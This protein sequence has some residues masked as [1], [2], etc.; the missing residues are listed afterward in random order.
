[1]KSTFNKS[2]NNLVTE[3]PSQLILGI[4]L[5]IYI[6]LN[7]QTPLILARPIDTLFGK[8]VVVIIAIILFMKTNP[9][10]G[11]LGFMV[12]YQLI[13]TATV[14]TGTY[15]LK[16]FLPSEA[17]KAKEMR[18]MNDEKVS[19]NAQASSDQV[20]AYKNTLEEEMVDRMVPLV[21]HG[22]GIDTSYKPILDG[23]HGAA[24]L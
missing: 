2:V 22:G 13:K 23:Q 19:Y 20:V 7:I 15:G 1:M 16:H 17:S 5:I 3:R 14:T 4:V 18:A 24:P 10:I 21:V 9:V 6:L 12:A 11:I 8:V